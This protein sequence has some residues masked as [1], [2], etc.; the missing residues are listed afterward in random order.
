M[1]PLAL[2]WSWM[3]YP[4]EMPVSPIV[5]ESLA[6]VILYNTSYVS[7]ILAIKITLTES[8][9][10]RHFNAPSFMRWPREQKCRMESILCI[11]RIGQH[12]VI[13]TS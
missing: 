12:P 4:F 7:T 6:R 1:S 10:R 11:H 5:S 3:R 8:H 2:R 13:M 9:S